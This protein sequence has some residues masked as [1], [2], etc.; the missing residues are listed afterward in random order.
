MVEPG[1]I[2]ATTHVPVM[3]HEIVRLLVL[4]PAGL[5]VD[6]TAGGGGHSL[7][8]L[9]ASSPDGRVLSL[10]ADPVAVA[11][12]RQRLARFG[13]RSLVVQANFRDLDAVARQAGFDA[14]DGILL[15]LG[16]SSDQLAD[17]ARGFSLMENGPLDM[18]F[19]PELPVTAADLINELEEAELADLIYRYGE[20]RQSRR[21]A[22]AI[23]NSRPLYTSAELRAVIERTLG[24]KGKIHPA[25]RTFQALRIAVNDELGVL[26]DV[27][28]KTLQLMRPGGR[29][30]VVSFHSLE[31]RIVKQF[32]RV[33]SMD[34]IC[35]PEVL[36]CS[37][38]HRAAVRVITRKP[39]RPS[40][41]ELAR[42]P[43]SRSAR[44]RAA[45]R[46]VAPPD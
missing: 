19:N 34:C 14:V 12:T 31:D 8:L 33:E 21:I 43:R 27:L 18:R 30:V 23:V 17:E 40:S 29:L 37:C 25:T 5:Y 16:L 24:R 20:E 2:P 26:V 13:Q 15:D 4:Q 42:N 38:D 7:A 35:P 44:L 28:P 39:L 46:L 32:M 6:G 45:E 1:Q 3:L 36:V 10:D 9:E 41:E 22:R 11:R